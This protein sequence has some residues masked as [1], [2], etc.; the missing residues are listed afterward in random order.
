VCGRCGGGCQGARALLTEFDPHPASTPLN[1]SVFISGTRL[2]FIDDEYYNLKKC[3]D[4]SRK[5]KPTNNIELLKMRGSISLKRETIR[6]NEKILN[7]NN[8]CMNE[9]YYK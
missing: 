9:S 6:K 7:Y 4:R 2:P 3:N 8:I 5:E 1:N